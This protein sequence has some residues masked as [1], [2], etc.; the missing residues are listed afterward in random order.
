MSAAAQHP[1]NRSPLGATAMYLRCYPYDMSQMETHQTALR[2]HARRLGL[3]DPVLY[4]DNGVR[5][6]GPRP[7]LDQFLR[8]VAAG[9]YTALLVTG[10]F[11]LSLCDAEA[12]SLVEGIRLLGCQVIEPPATVR[13]P[14]PGTSL[15]RPRRRA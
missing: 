4:L 5:S 7:A 10:P 15:L 14:T 2:L 13:H 3:R 11:M 12:R 6:P 9:A 8:R 1:L